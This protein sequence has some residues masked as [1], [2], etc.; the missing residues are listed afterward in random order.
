MKKSVFLYFKLFWPRLASKLEKSAN[1]SLTV[2][3]KSSVFWEGIKNEEFYTAL[4]QLKQFR[5]FP[6]NVFNKKSKGNFQFFLF[7]LMI[8]KLVGLHLFGV[9]FFVFFTRM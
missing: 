9:S 4:K 2:F 6:H 8:T 5:I 1:K 7:L 3:F